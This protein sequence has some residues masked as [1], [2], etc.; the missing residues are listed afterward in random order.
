VDIL[1]QRFEIVKKRL[2]N[3]ILS[4]SEV[5]IKHPQQNL[6][7]RPITVTTYTELLEERNRLTKKANLQLTGIE[8]ELNRVV[9]VHPTRKRTKGCFHLTEWLNPD[10]ITGEIP[11]SI[12][13]RKNRLEKDSGWLTGGPR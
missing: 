4:I 8:L 12:I 5:Y 2:Q 6:I 10:F 9:E 3:D 13:L 1:E 7:Y 11:E